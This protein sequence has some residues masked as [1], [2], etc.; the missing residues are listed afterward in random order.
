M[1]DPLDDRAPGNVPLLWSDMELVRAACL[2][3]AAERRNRWGAAGFL[4]WCV[5]R[6]GSL[7]RHRS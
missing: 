2:V 5:A 4:L 1:S 3:E 6:Y 7:R